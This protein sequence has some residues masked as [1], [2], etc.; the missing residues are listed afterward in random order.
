MFPGT[1][2]PTGSTISLEG[3]MTGSGFFCPTEGMIHGTFALSSSG[4]PV[5]IH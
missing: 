4:K 3:P 5:T 2:T 1:Y